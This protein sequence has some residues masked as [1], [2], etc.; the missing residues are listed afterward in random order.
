LATKILN[1]NYL[2]IEL[3]ARYHAAATKRLHPDGIRPCEEVYSPQN[4][5]TSKPMPPVGGAL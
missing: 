1:R 3:D 2:G 5:P 4:A